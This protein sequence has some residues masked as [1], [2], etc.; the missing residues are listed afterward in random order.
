MVKEDPDEAIAALH[1]MLALA[2]NEPFAFHRLGELL[3]SI[4]EFGQAERVYRRLASLVPDDP[5]VRARR[6]AL[7]A[8]ARPRV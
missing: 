8:M 3:A 4:D 2:P 1:Q 6:S 7:V 5:A